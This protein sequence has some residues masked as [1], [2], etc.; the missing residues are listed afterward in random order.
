MIYIDNFNRNLVIERYVDDV[1]GSLDFLE[2]KEKLKDCLIQQKYN[3]SNDELN[4][5][6]SRHDPGLL[7]D[8]YV[9]QLIEEVTHA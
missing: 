1:V 6:I 5:E 3:M 2:I 4:I 8:I 7:N 9:E